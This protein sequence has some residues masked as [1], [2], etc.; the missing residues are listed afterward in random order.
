MPP[1]G[2]KEGRE[3]ERKVEQRYG[4]E[5]VTCGGLQAAECSGLKQLCKEGRAPAGTLLTAEW[6]AVQQEKPLAVPSAACRCRRR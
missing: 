2:K 4:A 6:A 1:G 3:E 5:C